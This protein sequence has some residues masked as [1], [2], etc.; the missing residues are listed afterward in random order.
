MG[1]KPMNPVAKK[2]ALR[3]EIQEALD[4]NSVGELCAILARDGS[5]PL[6]RAVSMLHVEAVKALLPCSDVNQLTSIHQMSALELCAELVLSDASRMQS[7]PSYDVAFPE[8]GVLSRAPPL[9]WCDGTSSSIAIASLLLGSKAAP[10]KALLTAAKCPE[11]DLGLML[12]DAKADVTVRDCGGRTPL[13]YAVQTCPGL[14]QRLLDEGA[15]PCVGQAIP[16]SLP[17]DV[18]LPDVRPV[19][20]KAIRWREVRLFVWAHARETVA[21]R[22]VGISDLPLSVCHKILLLLSS[23]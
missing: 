18:A 22:T 6:H 11:P 21:S 14:V 19:L 23:S 3:L 5:N 16:L 17:Y 20:A 7:L 1:E 9:P 12:L 4:S 13:W 15:D 10:G 2:R 8:V